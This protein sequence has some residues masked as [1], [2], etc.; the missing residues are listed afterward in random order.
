MSEGKNPV[1]PERNGGEKHEAKTNTS[2]RIGSKNENC[3]SVVSGVESVKLRA[4][5]INSI[6]VLDLKDFTI[7]QLRKLVDFKTLK[8]K[9]AIYFG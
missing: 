9:D 6:D 3:K 5:D 4:V 1:S 2:H 8:Y 7:E